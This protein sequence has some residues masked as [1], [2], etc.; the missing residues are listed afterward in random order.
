MLVSSNS[1]WLMVIPCLALGGCASLTTYKSNLGKDPGL[2]VSVDM[3]Q[4]LLLVNKAKVTRPVATAQPAKG[5]HDLA[6]SK[7][8]AKPAGAQTAGDAA[9]AEAPKFQ[10]QSNAV[11]TVSWL[12]MCAEPSPDALASTAAALGSS[13]KAEKVSVETSLTGGESA[14]FVGLRTTSVQLLRDAMYRS[15]EA[16]LNSATPET[17]EL[18]YFAAQKRFQALVVGLLAIE[19]LTNAVRAPPVVMNART[20]TGSGGDAEDAAASLKKRTEEFA[21]AEAKASAARDAEKAATDERNTRKAAYE[22]AMKTADDKSGQESAKTDLDKADKAL[23][24]ARAEREKADTIATMSKRLADDARSD[25][26]A[27]RQRTHAATEGTG[28][29]TL[30]L[31]SHPLSEAVVKE[32]AEAVGKIV[33]RVVGTVG[34]SD[35]PPL[36]ARLIQSGAPAD[37][38]R[39]V[40][41]SC[42]NLTREQTLVAE[43]SLENARATAKQAEATLR[44]SELLLQLTSSGRFSAKDWNAVLQFATGARKE[45]AV[46]PTVRTTPP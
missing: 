5:A 30:V 29:P 18:E 1:R 8:E 46:P 39:A 25:Y 41:D 43:A 28:G 42:V 35:C 7:G 44:N 22:A 19:Q 12:R 36:L 11:E 31:T 13:V 6:P 45:P 4:R 24:D 21:E 27:A 17:A 16:Y 20:R 32:A 38:V 40:A 3:K 10:Q 37:Q 9:P 34:A 14:A 2:G 33:D 15:C 23:S 26:E